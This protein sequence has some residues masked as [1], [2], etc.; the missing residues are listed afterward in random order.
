[1]LFPLFTICIQSNLNPIEFL[2][3]IFWNHP[4]STV[5]PSRVAVCGGAVPR[6]HKTRSPILLSATWAA[7]LMRP[8]PRSRAKTQP[9]ADSEDVIVKMNALKCIG[10]GFAID[11]FGTGDSS[12]SY[13][14]RL[15]LERLKIDR[16]LSAIS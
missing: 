4:G 5:L 3:T 8:H 1:M 12:L 9:L 7:P 11:D 14:T 15:P 6:R 2:C 16:V 13:L 10:I